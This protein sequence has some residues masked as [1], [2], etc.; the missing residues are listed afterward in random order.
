M[1]RAMVLPIA[2]LLAL[3]TAAPVAAQGDE[4]PFT[5]AVHGHGMV[6]PDSACPPLE[7]RSVVTTTGFVSDMGMIEL[8]WYNCTPEGADVEGIEMTFV[9]ENGDSVSATYGASNA[10]AVG[11]DPMLMEI[12]YDF[13]I[14]GG[15]G[16]YEGA[17]G[18]GQLAAMMAWP[19]FEPN[20]WPALVLIDGTISY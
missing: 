16:R 2:L 20:Y 15:T 9:D 5:G 6:Q 8:N 12:D 1:K 13:E 17:T 14:V 3:A 4:L 7:L 10:P 18:G 19:G 11:E